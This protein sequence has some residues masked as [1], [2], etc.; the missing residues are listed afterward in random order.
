MNGA[1]AE[2]ST[3]MT[4][5]PTRQAIKITGV[6]QNFLRLRRKTQSSPAKLNIDLS[7][8]MPRISRGCGTILAL[9]APPWQQRFASERL[10]PRESLTLP[11]WNQMICFHQDRDNAS[12][13][14]RPSAAG[15][16]NSK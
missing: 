13:T 4:S 8:E 14:K 16:V 15:Y 5:P 1:I 9:F 11:R 3:N 12:I 6:S 10:R 7:A 2:P